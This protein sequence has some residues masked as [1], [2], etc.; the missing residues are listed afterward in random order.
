MRNKLALSLVVAAGLGLTAC[1]NPYDPGQRAVGGG[2]LGAGTGAAI[3][4]LVGGGRGAAAGALLGGGV[5][6]VGG[7]AS[8]PQGPV[9]QGYYQ[10][11]GYQQGGYYQEPAYERPRGRRYAPSGYGY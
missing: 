11:P 4:G 3:G 2:L 7:A 6:A 10:D 9:Q 1:S 5:G 8:T